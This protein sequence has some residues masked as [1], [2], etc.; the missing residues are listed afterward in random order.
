MSYLT[1]KRKSHERRS[2]NNENKYR[3]SVVQVMKQHRPELND[4]VVRGKCKNHSI[5]QK[6][7]TYNINRSKENINDDPP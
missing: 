6:K 2:H 1:D 7:E 3:L 5:I 4:I